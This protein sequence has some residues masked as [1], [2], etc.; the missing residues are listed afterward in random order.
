MPSE[1]DADPF[2]FCSDSDDEANDNVNQMVTPMR[3]RAGSMTSQ[4]EASENKLVKSELEE[5]EQINASLKEEQEL[6]S[7]QKKKPAIKTKTT[8]NVFK[9]TTRSSSK[10]GTPKKKQGDTV[11]TSPETKQ[12]EPTEIDTE[13]KFAK[14]SENRAPSSMQI[15]VDDPSLESKENSNQ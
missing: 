15:E 4:K 13:N 10:K 7:N 9:K 14:F 8:T 3:N 6:L 2:G 11:T 1:G 5:M 12:E